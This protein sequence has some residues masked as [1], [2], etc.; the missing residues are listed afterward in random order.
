MKL[1]NEL[2]P[3]KKCKAEDFFVGDL[4][5]LKPADESSQQAKG[6]LEQ[7]IA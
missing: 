3:R 1:W 2:H 5:L 6:D 4:N 7:M